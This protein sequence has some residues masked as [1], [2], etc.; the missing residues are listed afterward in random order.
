M[1]L[2]HV[3]TFRVRHYECDAYG[4]V[5]NVNYLRYMQETA[6][7]ASAAAGYDM[8]RYE[9]LGCHW[10]VR[11][12]EVEYLRPLRY[13]DSIEVK[14]WVADFRRVRS[15]RVYEM[16][17]TLTGT[18]VARGM[19]DW[20]YLETATGR[21]TPIPSEMMAAFFPDGPPASVPP[22]SRF[23][24]LPPAAPEV[25]RQRRRIEWRDLDP[26]QH[27]NNAIYLAYIEDCGLQVAAAYGW[28]QERMRQEG[29]AIVARRHQVQYLVPALMDDTVEIATWVSS[30]RHSTAL[31]HF[32]ISRVSDG[33][34]L[35]RARTLWV[36]VDTESGRLIRIPETFLTDFDPNISSSDGRRQ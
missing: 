23:P 32:V 35:A 10:L 2:T 13:G 24:A 18:V 22:R 20:V 7:D 33:A 25:Y 5:N 6:F 11:E 1:A 21:P 28:P 14:T 8:A 17:N 9:A 19:T 36:L 15:R 29:F 3:R 27:V 4:H 16:R 31:R 30:I 26:A 34:R 12:T